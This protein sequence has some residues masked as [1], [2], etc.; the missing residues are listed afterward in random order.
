MPTIAD[1][2]NAYLEGQADVDEWRAQFEMEWFA[3][4]RKMMER[5]LLRSIPQD[6]RAQLDPQALAVLEAGDE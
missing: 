6:V 4:L 1:A 5:A 2:E 3:P